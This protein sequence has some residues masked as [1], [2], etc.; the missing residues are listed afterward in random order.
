MGSNGGTGTATGVEPPGTEEWRSRFSAG[1]VVTGV[2]LLVVGLPALLGVLTGWLAVALVVV[3]LVLTQHAVAVPDDTEETVRG[4]ALAV[5][6]GLAAFGLLAFPVGPTT[7]ALLLA[8]VLG[9]FA[10]HRV[11]AGLRETGA[12]RRS[13]LAT[14]AVQLTLAALLAVGWPGGAHVRWSLFG[15]GLAVGGT[16]MAFAAVRDRNGRWR[17]VT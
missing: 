4:L 13:L 10:A 9:A 5:V 12:D 2:G 11:V 16:S 7:V 6:Y 15:V 17:T 1:V 3:A 8:G 14:A